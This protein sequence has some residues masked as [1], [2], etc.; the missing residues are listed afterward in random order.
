MNGDHPISWYHTFDGGR[1]WYTAM[2]HTSASFA[3]PLFRAHL[4][5]GILYAAELP[6]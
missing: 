2:G 4:W 3:E 5:G 1:A 6:S